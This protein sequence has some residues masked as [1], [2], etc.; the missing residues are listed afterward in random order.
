[1]PVVAVWL[2]PVQGS[3][4]T[5]PWLA[6]VAVWA[7]VPAL[8]VADTP[9]V[10]TAVLAGA[11]PVDPGCLDLGFCGLDYS[12]GLGLAACWSRCWELGLLL[13]CLGAASSACIPR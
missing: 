10:P 5:A 6:A 2:L 12:C 7:P 4:L 9:A 13:A 8:V 3:S 1:V 11:S